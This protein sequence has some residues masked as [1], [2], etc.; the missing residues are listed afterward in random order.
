MSKD[1]TC[2]VKAKKEMKPNAETVAAMEELKAG[3]GIKFI[4]VEELFNSI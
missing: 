2:K 4:W 1:K 3:K